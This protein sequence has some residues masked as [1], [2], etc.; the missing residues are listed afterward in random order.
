VPLITT[1]TI[2]AIDAWLDR[3]VTAAVKQNL[4]KNF[5]ILTVLALA[6]RL[7]GK[8]PWWAQAR[9]STIPLVHGG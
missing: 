3:G 4:K 9:C 7:T 1:A 5:R 8:I 2:A 6:L